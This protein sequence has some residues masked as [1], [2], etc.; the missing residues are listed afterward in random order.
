MLADAKEPIDLRS[1]TLASLGR[2]DEPWVSAVVLADY[3]Q[4]EPDLQPK[5]IDLLT[6]R[7]GW[8]HAL[9]DAIGRHEIPT[10]ALN[11][12]QVRKLMASKDG[13]LVEKVRTQWGTLRTDRNPQREQVIADIRKLLVTRPG[14]PLAG[15]VVFNRVCGQCHKI[16]GAGQEVGPDLTSNGRSSME[17]LL[18]NVL[19]PSLVIGA[20]YLARIV[21]TDDGRI[22]TGL[23][24]ED[25]DERLVLKTQGGKLET[26]AR[27]AIEE[28]RVSQLSM[29]PEELEKQLKPEEIID[30]FAF[31]AL[32][33]PPSDPAARRLPG[34]EAPAAK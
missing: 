23:P 28:V 31:L 10:S 25:N 12:N 27:T 11:L 29:M 24:V 4:F 34:L 14:D 7:P 17:Q 1:Q 8:S 21:V 3:S 13:A 18:S 2:A 30:L 22:L 19:D 16:Y 26:I 32:D 15:Q 9:L 33:K 20:G 6:E 5:A